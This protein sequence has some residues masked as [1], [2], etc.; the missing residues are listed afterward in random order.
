MVLVAAWKENEETR[1]K[2]NHFAR[3]FRGLILILTFEVCVRKEK[4]VARNIL[5]HTSRLL[6]LL[7]S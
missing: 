7:N 1:G 2:G 6:K 4:V 5:K 3:V